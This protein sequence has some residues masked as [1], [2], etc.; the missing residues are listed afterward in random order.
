MSLLDGD[1]IAQIF[2]PPIKEL[3]ALP[4][5]L[6]EDLDR[7]ADWLASRAGTRTPSRRGIIHVPGWE[8]FIHLYPEGW[9]PEQEQTKR[10][11]ERAIRISQSP[12]PE[13]VRAIGS[14]MTWVDDVQDALV[15]ASV[16]A[17]LV[18]YFY[19]P[20]LPVAAGLQSAAAALNI[21]G[22]SSQV[23]AITLTGKFRG[24]ALVRSLIGAQ[25]ARARSA[26]RISRVLPTIGEGIQIAQTTDQLFGFGLSLGPL[27][28]FIQDL[29]FGVPAGAEFAF[30]SGIRYRPNDE[31]WLRPSDQQRA[32]RLELHGPIRQILQGAGAAAWILGT[33]D[34]PTFSDRV[35]AL[36]LLSLS[37]ELG[38]GF[39]TEAKWEDLV[40]PSLGIPRPA[41]S[42][43]RPKTAVS[44]YTARGVPTAPESFPVPG[45]PRELS[46]QDQATALL[47]CGPACI[48]DWLQEAPSREARL[49]AEQL[50]TDLTPRMVR[51]F[52][53]AGT[54]FE[55][56]NAPPWRAVIDSL[57]LGLRPPPAARSET[58]RAYLQ[59]AAALYDNQTDREIPTRD[60]RALHRKH[61]PPA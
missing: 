20:A 38:R 10:R 35:D 9:L 30:R 46:I 25:S 61:Y 8:D 15:T 7:G 28:G 1:T 45:N 26:L 43:I 3:L 41:S 23:G 16:L 48:H 18:A 34:G 17:R 37:A 33:K 55:T 2:E 19:K 11:R 31:V 58:N 59:E 36:A 21:F 22:L 54:S 47:R 53:G 12:T 24:Q 56:H 42:Q 14:I 50:A 39:L 51:A 52:E 44:I 32:E 60:L 29:V 40:R 13:S 5:L 57:E 6:T 4:D 27:I 49:F